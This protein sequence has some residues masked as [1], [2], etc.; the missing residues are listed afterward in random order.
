MPYEGE[1][2]HCHCHDLFTLYTICI[3]AK[4][5]GVQDGSCVL[6]LD[7]RLLHGLEAL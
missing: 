4:L 5:V 1:S 3:N 7:L 6:L 2:T